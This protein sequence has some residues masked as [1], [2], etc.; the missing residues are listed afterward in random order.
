[1]LSN[2]FN[3][4]FLFTK[5]EIIN[6]AFDRNMR[7]NRKLSLFQI[8][9]FAFLFI[10]L[11]IN[12]FAQRSNC[13]ENEENPTSK[14]SNWVDG[15]SFAV[16]SAYISPAKE[17]EKPITY[18]AGF[19]PLKITSKPRATHTDASRKNC[20]EGKVFLRLTFFSD[21]TVGNIKVIKGLPFGLSK[22]AI[23]AAKKIK[24]EP[25]LKNDKPIS[26]TKKIEYGFWLY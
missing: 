10:A 9:A 19:K 24:F 13:K 21:G 3:T 23:E 12:A 2:K 1:M 18:P 20:V 7:R 22:Q 26:V 17:S 25:Q 14:K 4:V 16:D 5:L 6:L 8:V 15:S 11:S